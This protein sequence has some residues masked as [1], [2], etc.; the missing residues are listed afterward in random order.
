M[1]K[2]CYIIGIIFASD[3]GCNV[4]LK[5]VIGNGKKTHNQLHNVIDKR[6]INLHLHF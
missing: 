2:F 5:K 3:G 4:K 6:S 1:L